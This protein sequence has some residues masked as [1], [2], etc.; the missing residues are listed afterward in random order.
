MRKFI[1]VEIEV[2][3]L[4]EEIVRTSGGPWE[5]GTEKPGTGSGGDWY[6]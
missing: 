3:F 1:P 2:L 6:D 5:E 4:E